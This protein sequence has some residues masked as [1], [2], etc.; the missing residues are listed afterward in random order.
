MPGD[1]APGDHDFG[2]LG[3]LPDQVHEYTR[4]R[5]RAAAGEGERLLRDAAGGRH[6][7]QRGPLDVLVGSLRRRVRRA[8]DANNA[9][10]ET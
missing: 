4:S 5:E 6:P 2:P 7:G 9:D 3:G 8:D 1:A 10:C